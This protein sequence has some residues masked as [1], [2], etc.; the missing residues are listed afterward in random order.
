MKTGSFSILHMTTPALSKNVIYIHARYVLLPQKI[1]LQISM[2]SSKVP[3]LKKKGPTK[4]ITSHNLIRSKTPVPYVVAHLSE[5]A[6]GP[7]VAS[8]PASITVQAHG[9]KQPTVF[10][11]PS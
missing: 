6:P 9:S 8:S 4:A 11:C 5:I 7:R 1:S 3:N 10:G 2:R